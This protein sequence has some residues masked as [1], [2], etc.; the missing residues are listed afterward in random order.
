VATTRTP[1]AENDTLRAALEEILACTGAV[2]YRANILDP[3]EVVRTPS[4]AIGKIAALA[5]MALTGGYRPYLPAIPAG[6]SRGAAMDEN[7]PNG[8]HDGPGTEGEA[9]TTTHVAD[10]HVDPQPDAPAANASAATE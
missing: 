8:D 7:A 6:Q 4:F 10:G 1:S 9:D 2:D 3:D 5:S